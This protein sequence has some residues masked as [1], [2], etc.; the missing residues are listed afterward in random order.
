MPQVV[1]CAVNFSEGRDLNAAQA[2]VDSAQEVSGSF[3]ITDWSADPD[4]NRMVV[5]YLGDLKSVSEAVFASAAKAVELIDISKHNGAHPRLGAVDVVPLTP[6]S[7]TTIEDCA[8]TATKLGERFWHELGLPVFLYE[9]ASPASRSLPEIRRRAFIDWL[10]DIGGSIP[11][12]TAGAA[13]VGARC[14]LIAFNANL[15]SSD[16]L[17]AKRIAREV[18]NAYPGKARALGIYLEAQKTAQVSMNIIDP[19]GTS[20]VELVAFI[21]KRSEIR[22]C[23]L[24]GAAPSSSINESMREPLKLAKLSPGQIINI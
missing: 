3:R 21:D 4:H 18:R 22:E 15:K 7:E 23:E 17:T 9:S 19:A 12:P 20:L 11:H 5:T 2:I 24:I 10:P 8:L 1:Q 14:P 6:I 13:V 16:I